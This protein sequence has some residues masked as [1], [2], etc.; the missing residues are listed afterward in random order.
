[1]ITF[2]FFDNRKKTDTKFYLTKAKLD[3]FFFKQKN[4]NFFFWLK[5]NKPQRSNKKNFFLAHLKQLGKILFNHKKFKVFCHP[6]WSILKRLFKDFYS[7]VFQSYNLWQKYKKQIFRVNKNGFFCLMILTRF[8]SQNK[9]NR[10]KVVRLWWSQ[11]YWVWSP[12]HVAWSWKKIQ[13]E[14]MHKIQI[15]VWI[16]HETKKNFFQID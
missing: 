13:C 10:E 9:H 14:K 6:D 2:F 1:M 3:T 15:K 7:A 4:K 8:F 16:C 5:I 12:L 11:F